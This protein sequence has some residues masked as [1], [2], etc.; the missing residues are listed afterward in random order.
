MV[1]LELFHGRKTPT[2]QLDDWGELGPVFGPFPFVH[3]TY[4]CEI[5]L[6]EQAHVLPILLPEGMTYYDGMYYGDWSVCS[7]QIFA[8]NPNLQARLRAFEAAKACL[9]QDDVSKLRQETEE[10]TELAH[11]IALEDCES[12]LEGEALIELEDGVEW[13]DMGD[14]P[15]RPEAVDPAQRYLEMRGLLIR[16]PLHPSWIRIADEPRSETHA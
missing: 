9:P 8:D 3:T 12:V 14:E 4:A 15:S 11:E 7:A 5:K 16:H 10:L 6:G 13:W 2:E 1:Y